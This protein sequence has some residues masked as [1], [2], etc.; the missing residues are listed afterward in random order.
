MLRGKKVV[1]EIKTPIL[2]S[3]NFSENRAVYEI[4]C[5]NV[6]DPDRPQ[7]TA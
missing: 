6:V 1:E 2:C 3:G 4:L 7:R 5:R